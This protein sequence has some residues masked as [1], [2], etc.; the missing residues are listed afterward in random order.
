MST[1]TIEFPY[2][3]TLG[4]VYGAFLTGMRDGCILGMPRA[5]GSVLC[6]VVHIGVH[7]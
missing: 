4:P 1:S 2:T 6:L 5:D 3:R 7:L